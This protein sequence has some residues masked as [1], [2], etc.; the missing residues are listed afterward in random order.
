MFENKVRGMV[1]RNKGDEASGI[2]GDKQQ[3]G[4]SSA[5][6]LLTFVKSNREGQDK[7]DM[8]LVGRGETLFKILVRKSLGDRAV[9][10]RV[11]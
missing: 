7:S 10:D 5:D 2:N 4:E 3:L 1:S 9:D 6:N 11:G 8:L